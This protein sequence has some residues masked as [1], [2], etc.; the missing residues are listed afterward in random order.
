MVLATASAILIGNF[1]FLT[2][3]SFVVMMVFWPFVGILAAR[4]L[5]I[6]A[7]ASKS[8]GN[9]APFSIKIDLREE[10]ITYEMNNCTRV[11]G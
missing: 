10:R 6:I 8:A 11:Q 3:P 7:H 4:W 9:E 2:L 5:S 1:F